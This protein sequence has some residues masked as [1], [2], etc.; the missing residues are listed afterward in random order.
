M[1]VPKYCRQRKRG[2]RDLAYAEIPG[3]GRVYLGLYDTP[4][5]KQAYERAL[6]ELRSGQTGPIPKSITVMEIAAAYAKHCEGYYRKSGEYQNVLSIDRAP[7]PPLR[8]RRG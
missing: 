5:S 4:E 8:R 1:S 7:L 2:G 3:Q 6:A